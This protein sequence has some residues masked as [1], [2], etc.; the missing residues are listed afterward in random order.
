VLVYDSD[1]AGI[2]SA[3]RCIDLFWKEHVDFRRDDVFREERADTHILVLPEG[4]DPDSFLH[5]HGVEAFRRFA[6]SAP[7]VITFVMEQAVQR[8]GLSTEGKLRIVSELQPYVSAINDSVARALYVQQLAERVHVDETVI[9]ERIKVQ[10][11][12]NAGLRREVQAR[13]GGARQSI[14][15]DEPLEQQII[16]MMLQFPEI[17]NEINQ[18]GVLGHFL[19]PQL[20]AAGERILRQRFES[21]EQLP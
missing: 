18:N 15:S 14:G 17:I 2:R 4:H 9:L 21:V 6:S 12:S 13:T 7:G 3:R 5:A 10:G 11:G 20:K 1:E 16:A 8:Y 19:N